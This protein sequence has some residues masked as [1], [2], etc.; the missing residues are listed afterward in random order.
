M[1]FES[2]NRILRKPVIC[3]L[4]LMIFRELQIGFNPIPSNQIQI[5]MSSEFFSDVLT[6]SYCLVWKTS[7][8]PQVTSLASLS[9]ILQINFKSIKYKVLQ[10]STIIYSPPERD[11]SPGRTKELS[12]EC[13]SSVNGLKS[14][15]QTGDLIWPSEI[16]C[17]T[18][19]KI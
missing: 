1:F 4:S 11:V 5:E 16:W 13:L 18:I 15:L 9:I 10:Y 8:I 17:F 14:E 6:F 12:A 3:L 7:K 2:L 19:N